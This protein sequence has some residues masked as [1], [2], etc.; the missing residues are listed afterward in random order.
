MI[1]GSMHDG[2]DDEG[3]GVDW[4]AQAAE[5][6]REFLRA[7]LM[8]HSMYSGSSGNGSVVGSIP[9]T[10]SSSTFPGSLTDLS[11]PSSGRFSRRLFRSPSQ[12]SRN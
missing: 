10:A 11:E 4:I 6:E 3:E 12:R 2:D 9:A 5:Y 8:R 7:E 1:I